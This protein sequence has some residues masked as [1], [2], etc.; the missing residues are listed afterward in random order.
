MKMKYIILLSMLAIT[1]YCADS[2]NHTEAAPGYTIV[3][4]GN[5]KLGVRFPDYIIHGKHWP[6]FVID[7]DS[8]L[9]PLDTL[10]KA[11]N[12]SWEEYKCQTDGHL[13]AMPVAAAEP[14]ALWH[15][16][17]MASKKG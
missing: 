16:F 17:D 2:G 14:Q 11:I 8:H 1:G 3:T 10:Q 7:T 9:H 12:R 5:G 4:D 13:H 6:G 15:P